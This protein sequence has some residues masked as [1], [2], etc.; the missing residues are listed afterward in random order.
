MPRSDL[1]FAI[2]VVVLILCAC[3]S[4]P[5]SVS[6]RETLAVESPS[7]T[8]TL[9]STDTFAIDTWFWDTDPVQGER[10]TF[11]GCLVKNGLSLNG[12]MMDATWPD[13][14]KELGMGSCHVMVNYQRGVCTIYTTGLPVG[15]YIPVTVKF[16]Y[17]GVIYTKT[18]GFTLR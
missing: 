11:Y 5:G 2:L 18:T 14:N 6:A 12:I 3:S 1:R 17:Q 7:P 9:P 16:N 4:Q 13:K 10:V 15:E 8:A